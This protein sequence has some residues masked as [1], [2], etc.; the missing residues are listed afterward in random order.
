MAK[1]ERFPLHD[2][3]GYPLGV[4]CFVRVEAES[5]L[6]PGRVTEFRGLVSRI[7]DYPKGICLT[8]RE[9]YGGFTG[10]ERAARPEHCRVEKAPRELREQQASKARRATAVAGTPRRVVRR[11]P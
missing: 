1:G 2:R 10:K 4:D 6:L 7:D 5:T 3:D 9:W 11:K 8:V